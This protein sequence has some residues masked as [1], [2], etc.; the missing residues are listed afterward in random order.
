VPSNEIQLAAHIQLEGMKNVL[1]ANPTEGE[2]FIENLKML[3]GGEQNWVL[4]FLIMHLSRQFPQFY[5]IRT[6]SLDPN[7]RGILVRWRF[8][9]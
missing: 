7:V 8:K 2:Y 6:E 9:R 4:T 3:D 5:F 1:I